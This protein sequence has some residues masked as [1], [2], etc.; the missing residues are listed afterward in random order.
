MGSLLSNDRCAENSRGRLGFHRRCLRGARGP[1]PGGPGGAEDL[2]AAGGTCAAGR[3][4]RPP[5]Y[6][7]AVTNPEVF[8]RSVLLLVLGVPIPIILLLAFCTHHF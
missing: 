1:G 8:M 3:R 6:A 5:A 7:R 2:R 4:F